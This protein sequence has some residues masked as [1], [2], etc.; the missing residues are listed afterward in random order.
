MDKS[1]KQAMSDVAKSMKTAD[2]AVKPV[3]ETNTGN[4]PADNQVMIR[5]T[6]EEKEEWRKAAEKLNITM[7]SFIR[8]ILNARARELLYCQ[9]PSNMRRFYPWAEF[10]LECNS[11]IRG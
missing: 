2:M 3:A 10:C 7:S 5:V 11:R 9:H 4:V 8:D 6:S 1:L